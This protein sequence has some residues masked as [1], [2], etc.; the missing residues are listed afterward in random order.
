MICSSVNLVR[1]IVRPQV[2]PDSNRRWG[3]NPVAGHARQLGSHASAIRSILSAHGIS[4]QFDPAWLGAR[5]YRRD[6]V[7]ELISKHQQLRPAKTHQSNSA[8]P[9]AAAKADISKSPENAEF[10]E[11][12]DVIL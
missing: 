6:D 10:C 11:S 4:P 3:K 1:F 8:E 2:G 12:D 5:I 7:S 9:I